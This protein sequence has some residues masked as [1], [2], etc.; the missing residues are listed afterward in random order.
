MQV[1]RLLLKSVRGSDV[2]ARVG[3]DEFGVLLTFTGD[4]GAQCKAASIERAIAAATF[5]FADKDG[6]CK[7]FRLGASIGVHACGD[8]A[9]MD[10][11]AWLSLAD[12]AMRKHKGTKPSHRETGR[13]AAL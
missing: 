10:P 13:S 5:H 7:E 6:H 8:D 12:A 4:D 9:D 11:E 3:G 1:G 2:V